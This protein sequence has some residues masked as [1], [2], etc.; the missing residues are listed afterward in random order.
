MK[1][2]SAVF[3]P[4]LST[5]IFFISVFAPAT[6]GA[7]PAD[8]ATI[9]KFISRAKDLHLAESDQWIRF[10]HYRPTTFGGMKSEADGMNFFVVPEGRRSPEAELNATLRGFFSTDKRKLIGSR[11]PAQSVQCQF[12]AR[13][14]W[15][16]SQLGLKG[17][18]PVDDCKEWNEFRDRMAT[19]SVTLVFSSFYVGN[20]SS[21]FGHSLVRLNKSEGAEGTEH[22]QL[23][24]YGVN[25]AAVR[26]VDNPLLYALFG[27]AGVFEGHFT[28]LPYYYKVREYGDFESRDLWEY[29]LNLTKEETDRFVAH[30]WELGSTYFDYFYLTENCSYH[31]L[32]AIEAAAPRV[33]LVDHMPFWIL[34]TD[35]IKATFLEPGLVKRTNFRA[36]VYSQFKAR[37]DR[38]NDTEERELKLLTKT[39]QSDSTKM[40]LLNKTEF[41]AHAKARVLDAYIDFFDLQHARELVDKDETLVNRKQRLLLARSQLPTS[42]PLDFSTPPTASP[43]LAHDSMKLTLDRVSNQNKTDAT[44]FGVRFAF[45]DLLDPKLGLPNTADIEFFNVTYR[46]WDQSRRLQLEDWALFGVGNYQPI[47]A[48]SQKL[49]WR[50]RLGVHRIDDERCGDCEAGFAKM[51]FG[52][53]IYLWPSKGWLGYLLGEA[54]FDGSPV[55]DQEKYSTSVGPTLGVRLQASHWMSFLTEARYAR[56]INVP[57]FD[58]HELD[59]HLRFYPREQNVAWGLDL[60]AKF[61]DSGREIT[62]GFVHYE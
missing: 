10:G 51:G 4:L 12:P 36:S 60:G 34:P 14:A 41:D 22:H 49:T 61:N 35:T 5:V 62:F 40:D 7:N 31:M 59:S 52:G 32:T 33:H 48:Y 19:K 55:F 23:L 42:Q 54:S 29:D 1:Y 3:F 43:N 21:T 37:L 53:S 20:P 30:M 18:V 56:S 44:S 58:H 15:L 46:Y 39:E 9:Q 28:S 24:D 27:L 57:I 26:T 16:D 11:Q 6:S 47:N 8:E 50:G 2:V 13:F 17:A 45:H 38:L 25:Y